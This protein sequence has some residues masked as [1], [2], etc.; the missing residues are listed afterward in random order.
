MSGYEQL[1]LFYLGKRYDIDT[2]TR[3]SEPILY[4]SKDLVTHAMCVG[5]T[6]S[7]KTG[8][9][10]TLIEEAAI[11]GVPVLAIDPKG[12][13]ANLLLT[14][15][16]LDSSEFL[17]WIDPAEAATRKL[18][19]ED[20]AAAEAGRWRA[21]LAEWDQ[22]PERIAM[23]RA[24]A[25]VRLYTPGS[26]AATPLA[27]LNSIGATSEDDDPDVRAA[28]LSSTAASL[29][30]L[31]GYDAVEQ[32]SREQALIAAIL[33][34]AGTAPGP[35]GSSRGAD[36]GWLV[37]QVQRPSFDRVGVLDLETF[38]PARERQELALR[39]N[40]VLASPGFD[41]WLSGDPLDPASLLFTP[42]GNPR[43][44]IVSIAHLDDTKRMLVVSLL[45]NAVLQWTR[46]QRGTG[47]L[48]ALVYMD[49]VFGYLPPV[50]NPPSK[51][52][53]L[54]LLKQARAFGVGIT[55]ATQNPVDLDYKALSN[56]G[57]WFLGKLQ[58][59][60]D[61]TRVL[62]GLEGAGGGMERAMLDR[63]L[64]ALRSRVFLMHNVNE[65]APVLF[66]TRWTLS[67]LRGP[68][69]RDELRRLSEDKSQSPNPKSQ[70]P[71]AGPASGQAES[72]APRAESLTSKPVVPAGIREVF[73]DAKDGDAATYEPVLYGA[74]RVHYTDS[75]RGIDVTQ[76]V[77]ATVPFSDGAVAV[78]WDRADAETELPEQLA[79][80]SP[81]TVAEFA[82]PP[83]DAL[84]PKRYVEWSR[85]FE[86]WVVRARPLTL[87]AVR[88]LK[89][90]S[91]PGESERDFRI[92][93]QQATR[94]VRDAQVEKLRAKYA[95]QVARVTTKVRQAEEALGREQQQAQ[96]QKVQ[97]AVSFG[98]TLLGAVLGR[99]AVS[100]STL[101]RATTAARGV[102]RAAKEIEDV[103]RAQ[104]RVESAQAELA[105]LQEQMNRE[106]EGLTAGEPV[107]VET[108]PV[109]AKR[110]AIDV[111]L[112]AL[113]WKPTSRR[114][115]TPA[116][117]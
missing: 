23:L 25:P 56:I 19:A 39:F 94:E 30:A 18:S 28:D 48:R 46:R 81:S 91:R 108:L 2:Q 57:T 100:L 20:Y 69:G 79:T 58:T 75:R 63:T 71:M 31:V 24:A 36:L 76:D 50:A 35:G 16:R 88:S 29:L 98:A 53:L 43:V 114:S 99:R 40:S 7:G 17:P 47:S 33:G 72:P 60:R 52:P 102:S 78:D 51:L 38:Y 15:P 117:P 115:A 104:D 97:T 82:R 5:M 64:S 21:G 101:G 105:Q 95:A 49:E 86:Q 62:D 89:L 32:H 111:R 45:L 109:K 106:V 54:T 70:V 1:G 68:L 22:T 59:E 77:I 4:D 103:T 27:I 65:P 66:E 110:G 93:V 9:G 80:T 90:T 13:L 116:T 3:T 61:K 113:A 41:V 8:L 42:E 107:D 84:N 83:V 10:I 96:Q 74:A 44:A 11:D 14:F 73:F 92:R 34:Q 55:L 37:Q 112:I 85:D 12:D 67:Y 87:Y 6:G 26:R